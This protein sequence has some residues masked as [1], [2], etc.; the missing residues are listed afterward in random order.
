MAEDIQ[1]RVKLLESDPNVVKRVENGKTIYEQYSTKQD[2]YRDRGRVEDKYVSTRTIVDKGKSITVERFAVQRRPNEIDEIYVPY[3]SELKVYRPVEGVGWDLHQHMGYGMSGGRRTTTDY[4]AQRPTPF[5]KPGAKRYVHEGEGKVYVA[6]VKR[7]E[8]QKQKI[9]EYKAKESPIYE[10]SYHGKKMYTPDPT[11]RPKSLPT[12]RE[13][14]ADR[15]F[16]LQGKDVK[17]TYDPATR[18]DIVTPKSAKVDVSF[19]APYL[20][21]I[22]RERIKKKEPPKTIERIELSEAVSEE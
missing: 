12:T 20:K 6:E 1:S 15:L 5:E 11:Y 19:V 8:E 21:Q 14:F 2:Y 3:K 22:E 10:L 9:A 16:G 7:T 13:D 17:Y 4:L 18:T